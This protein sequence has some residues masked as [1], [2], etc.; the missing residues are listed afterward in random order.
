MKITLSSLNPNRFSFKFSSHKKFVFKTKNSFIRD[1]IAILLRCYIERLK[2][3]NNNFLCEFYLRLSNEKRNYEILNKS[4]GDN[5]LTRDELVSK[6]LAPI[7]SNPNSF[8]SLS[9]TAPISNSLLTAPISNINNNNTP[10]QTEA[11]AEFDVDEIFPDFNQDDNDKKEDDKKEEILFDEN[12]I[13]LESQNQHKKAW[14]K[15]EFSENATIA[16]E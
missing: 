15:L 12:E 13:D 9:F 16:S 2:R 6:I 14:K 5:T 10:S 1:N 4:K 11:E 7:S 8:T 3:N